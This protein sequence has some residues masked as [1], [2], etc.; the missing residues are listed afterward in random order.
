MCGL[1]GSHLAGD[2]PFCRGP[3]LM[4]LMCSFLCSVT[5]VIVV[6]ANSCVRVRMSVLLGRDLKLQITLRPQFDPLFRGDRVVVSCN[7]R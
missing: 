5:R 6:M 1:A 3:N 2:F 7:I 4:F